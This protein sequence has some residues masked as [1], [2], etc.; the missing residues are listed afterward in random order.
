MLRNG[1]STLAP[2]VHLT[3]STFP[4]T[5]PPPPSQTA[6]SFV[7]AEL[8]SND[9]QRREVQLEKLLARFEV[10]GDSSRAALMHLLLAGGG[11]AEEAYAVGCR[12]RSLQGLVEAVER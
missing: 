1:N 11:S 9:A 7:A 8:Q 10:P 12:Y 5:P 3:S 4:F 2:A 6:R